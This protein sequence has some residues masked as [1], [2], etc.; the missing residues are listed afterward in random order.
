MVYKCLL[1]RM[2]D[3][4][5]RQPFDGDDFLTIHVTN[6]VDTRA[7]RIVVN[8]YGAGAT[9][10][11]SAS[12]LGPGLPQL[13]ADDPQ[14][15]S[16]AVDIDVYGFSIES[17]RQLCHCVKPSSRL[18]WSKVKPCPGIGS[19]TDL[20]SQCRLGIVKF[21]DVEENN[22]ESQQGPSLSQEAQITPSSCQKA[23][24]PAEI[25]GGVALG[26]TVKLTAQ[27]V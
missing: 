14:K 2:Q 13:G 20:I 9:S 11:F 15:F 16:V 10:G 21:I 27:S 17:K 23:P 1:K 7:N 5:L 6:R 3:S 18:N 12:I 19:T 4:V 22:P 26:R 24:G 8:Q 25:D